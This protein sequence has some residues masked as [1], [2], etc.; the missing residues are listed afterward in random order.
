MSLTVPN[1]DE[2]FINLLQ[3]IYMDDE[4]FAAEV[5]RREEM[6]RSTCGIDIGCLLCGADGAASTTG[7]G[8]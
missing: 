6:I 3:A 1:V 8:Q 7:G 2:M 4:E 5:S